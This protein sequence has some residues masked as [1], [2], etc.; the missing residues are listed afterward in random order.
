LLSKPYYLLDYSSAARF[1]IF[2]TVNQENT[3]FCSAKQS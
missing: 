1:F 2:L 3:G